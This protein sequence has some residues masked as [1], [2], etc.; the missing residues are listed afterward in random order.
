MNFFLKRNLK[1]KS[2]LKNNVDDQKITSIIQIE[3]KLME[4]VTLIYSKFIVEISNEIII[5]LKIKIFFIC[6]A[7]SY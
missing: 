7:I 6:T 5:I 2:L 3:L 1:C 4:S